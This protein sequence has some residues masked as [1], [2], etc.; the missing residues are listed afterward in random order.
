MEQLFSQAQMDLLKATFVE[1]DACNDRHEK[2]ERE[3]STILI[4]QSK[5]STKLSFIQWLGGIAAGAGIGS[6]VTQICSAIFNTK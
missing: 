3:I 5:M 1:R 2:T 4:E 6:L